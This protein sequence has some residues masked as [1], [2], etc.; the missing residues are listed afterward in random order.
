MGVRI[1]AARISTLV[2]RAREKISMRFMGDAPKLVL[3]A[4]E[5]FGGRRKLV[6]GAR[7]KIRGRRKYLGSIQRGRGKRNRELLS[8]PNGRGEKRH[9]SWFLNLRFPNQQ[10]AHFGGKKRPN[11]CVVPRCCS[12]PGFFHAHAFF[13][14]R[15]FRAQFPGE[16]FGKG[17]TIAANSTLEPGE[18]SEIG[19]GIRRTRENWRFG[20]HELFGS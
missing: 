7:E 17:I 20:A 19:M 5:R 13:G 3:G 6:F 4:R 12:L 10:S 8:G 9:G 11:P 16:T 2:L 15:E 14:G 1:R 18:R